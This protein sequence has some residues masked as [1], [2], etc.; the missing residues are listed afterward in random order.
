MLNHLPVGEGSKVSDAQINAHILITHRQLLRGIDLTRERH[1]PLIHFSLNRHGLDLAV[2]W[3]MELDFRFADLAEMQ[4]VSIELPTCS[5]R[6][7]EAII[8]VTPLKAREA[9][10]FTMFAAAK[11]GLKC[12]IQPSQHILE[13]MGGYVLI[14]F[15]DLMLDLRQIILLIVVADGLVR[16]PVR[17]APF[18]E[19]SVVQL[20]AA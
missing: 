20:P 6:I 17:I 12:S 9:R 3:S 18:R 16:I 8:A 11:E 19:A 14:V 10:L 5:I 1:V 15:P 13:H 2:Y 7:G 4:G